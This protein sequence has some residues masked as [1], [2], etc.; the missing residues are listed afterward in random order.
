MTQEEFDLY[1]AKGYE[2]PGVEFKGP[3]KRQ[4]KL[5]PLL[6]KVIRAVMAM[7]NRPDGGLVILGVSEKSLGPSKRLDPVGLDEADYETWRNYD[8]VSVLLNSYASPSVSFDLERTKFHEKNFVIIHVKEFVDVPIICKKM[9][10]PS[11]KERGRRENPVIL[12]PGAC[13]VRSFHKPESAEVPHE[14]DMRAL[15]ELAIDKGLKKFV[16]RAYR[17]GLYVPGRGIIGKGETRPFDK[18]LEEIE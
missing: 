15:L 6:A 14:E 10:Q 16:E 1:L 7:A 17:A 8:E 4:T 5:T 18:Q 2:S 11:L 12:R 9:H 13:Y 3:C